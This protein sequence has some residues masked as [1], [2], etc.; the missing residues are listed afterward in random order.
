MEHAHHVVIGHGHYQVEFLD[1][2]VDAVGGL[3]LRACLGSSHW[4][5]RPRSCR[6]PTMPHHI[7]STHYRERNEAC[8]AFH[9]LVPFAHGGEGKGHGEGIRRKGT[10]VDARVW[11]GCVLA[12]V[13][14]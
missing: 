4:R 14:T 8:M 6:I 13:C 2:S 12:G 10:S 7:Q 1:L 3:L 5:E 9:E 11:V